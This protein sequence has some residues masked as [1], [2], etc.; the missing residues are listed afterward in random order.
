MLHVEVRV[1]GVIEKEWSDWFEGLAITALEPGATLL[2]GDVLDQAA[3][4][5]LL[6]RL[7]DLRFDLRSVDV[8]EVVA[9]GCRGSGCRGDPTPGPLRRRIIP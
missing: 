2:S 6:A 4:Y 1:K 3:L 9:G 5:G 7:R 8:C